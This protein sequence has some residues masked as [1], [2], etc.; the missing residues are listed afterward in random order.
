MEPPVNLDAENVVSEKVKLLKCI[1]PIKPD[2]VVIGQYTS[3]VLPNG[4]KI[5]GYLDDETGWI[6]CF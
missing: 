2:D 6:P 4:K 1:E 3:T 5:P